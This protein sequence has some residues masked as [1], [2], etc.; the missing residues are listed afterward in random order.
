MKTNLVYMV[1]IN[2]TQLKLIELFPDVIIRTANVLV[3]IVT[4]S[5]KAFIL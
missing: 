3:L 2:L 5:Y 1:Q 4:K